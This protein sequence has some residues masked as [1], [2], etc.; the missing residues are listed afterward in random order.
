MAGE[1]IAVIYT[2]KEET[3]KGAEDLILEAFEISDDEPKVQSLI[4]KIIH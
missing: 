3:I 4:Y 1:T 2:N